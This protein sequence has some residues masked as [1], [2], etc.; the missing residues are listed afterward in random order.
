MTRADIKARHALDRQLAKAV[1][2]VRRGTRWRSTQGGLYQARAG[3]FISVTPSVLM[4]PGVS[5][6]TVHA[7]PM[8]IDPIFWEIFSPDTADAPLSYRF[9]GT[10]VCREPEFTNCTVP[11]SGGA[12]A[13]AATILE[14]ADLKLDEIV[15]TMTTE[16][17]LQT[18]M[19]KNGEN[20]SYQTCV[21]CTL[22]ALHRHAEA[23]QV[24]R[25]GQSEQR[26]G[27]F[28]RAGKSFND[29][30]VDWL[31]TSITPLH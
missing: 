22:I 17:F 4:K 13:M 30:A 11:E 28:T 25:H 6:V 29:L 27:G 12:V 8:S 10:W 5:S 19:E 26:S 24:A 16:K 9:N 20:G 18:C 21:I 2:D 23:L 3:W 7:K 1:R 15:A 31:T 14:I